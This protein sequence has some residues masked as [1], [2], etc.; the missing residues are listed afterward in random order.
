MQN[1]VLYKTTKNKAYGNFL[2]V[3]LTFKSEGPAQCFSWNRICLAAMRTNAQLI[4]LFWTSILNTEWCELW[5]RGSRH[6][7]TSPPA[8]ME[9]KQKYLRQRNQQR[10][11]RIFSLPWVGFNE[12]SGYFSASP[13]K[14]IV[15]T[16]HDLFLLV[17]AP[18]HA[19]WATSAEQ[20]KNV[21]WTVAYVEECFI[22]RTAGGID[23]CFAR[24]WLHYCFWQREPDSG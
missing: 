17:N 24:S 7:V 15:E 23:V 16:S 8:P 2:N 5:T 12:S 10:P 3:C 22:Q 1:K 14:T 19:V 13:A 9:A 11:K 21:R 6:H 4:K 18:P 20:K